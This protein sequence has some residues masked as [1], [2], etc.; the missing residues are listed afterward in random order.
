[1]SFRGASAD[2]FTALS[3]QLDAVDADALAAVADDLF[4]VAAVL[5]N[6]PGL[7]RAATD[8]STE[9][10]AKSQLVSGIL[11]GKVSGQ[12]LEI[13]AAAAARRWTL[14][15]DLADALEQLGVVGLAKSAGQGDRLATE[16]F[17]VGQLIEQNDDLRAALSDPVRSAADKASLLRGLLEGKALPATIRLAEQGASGSYRT[18]T[19]ALEAYQKVAAAVQGEVVA[20]V[21]VARALSESEQG[22][23]AT[24]LQAQYGTNIHL[25]VIVEPALLGGMRVEIG[26]DVIDGTVSSRLEDAHRKLVG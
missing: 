17:E 8:V 24:A 7:R 11:E 10:G 14:T 23:L 13:V 26:D 4:G 6:E 20:K 1:M 2:A 19:A 16:L 18:V 3:N 25:D 5:R 12:A 9:A 22:R 15:R 21:R